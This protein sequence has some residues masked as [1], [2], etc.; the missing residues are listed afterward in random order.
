MLSK[1]FMR[2]FDHTWKI[3]QKIIKID[4]QNRRVTWI[5]KLEKIIAY[6]F[7]AYIIICTICFYTR[8]FFISTTA[9]MVFYF[10]FIGF[11]TVLDFLL[12]YT[13]IKTVFV[14]IRRFFYVGIGFSLLISMIICGSTQS[15][16]IIPY[17]Y[18]L[19]LVL[20]SIIL[21]LAWIYFSIL[22]NSKVAITAN[23]IVSGVLTV[24]TILIND[25]A[26][27]KTI[28]FNNETYIVS[29]RDLVIALLIING[30]ATVLATVKSYWTAK[31]NNGIE[32]IWDTLSASTYLICTNQFASKSLLKHYFECDKAYR[33][34]NSLKKNSSKHHGRY[35]G[36]VSISQELNISLDD[37]QKAI[38]TL[39]KE[40]II[41]FQYIHNNS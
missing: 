28:I 37:V 32:I 27:S 18:K 41:H 38:N 26:Q 39:E 33:V 9:C 36:D 15:L 3:Q 5:R 4:Y 1:F 7:I 40:D 35:L 14:S 22:A 30:L 29:L 20:L 21:G 31:Y 17:Y 2:L 25:S 19:L 23:G 24:T 8:I 13:Y 12:T 34:Y 11:Y 10:I 16:T 6:F